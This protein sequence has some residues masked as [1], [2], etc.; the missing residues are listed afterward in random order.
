MAGP[1]G[2]LSGFPAAATTDV[3]DVDGGPPGVLAAG[4]TATTTEAGDVD[5]EPPVSCCRDFRQRP[6]PMLKTSTAG[7]LGG[8]GGRSGSD[9]H[10]S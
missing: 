8:S 4:P 1:W 5:D 3:E 7:P 2:L 9:H 6:P 10:R